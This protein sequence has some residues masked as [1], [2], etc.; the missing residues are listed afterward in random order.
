[1]TPFGAPMDPLV[2]MMT[3]MSEGSGRSRSP[4]AVMLRHG[5]ICDNGE[6]YRTPQSNSTFFFYIIAHFSV[7][8]FL[9]GGLFLL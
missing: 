5:F 1:M 3:A 8:I 2:Y 7:V 9:C 6:L 4:A